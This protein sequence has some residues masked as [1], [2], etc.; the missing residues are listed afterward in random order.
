MQQRRGVDAEDGARLFQRATAEQETG[1][2]TPNSIDLNHTKRVSG[3]QQRSPGDDG[4]FLPVNTEVLVA[5]KEY[6]PGKQCLTVTQAA[7]A[8]GPRV[9]R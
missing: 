5:I 7:P 9:R 2:G 4:S 1:T 3:K 8:G 6:V